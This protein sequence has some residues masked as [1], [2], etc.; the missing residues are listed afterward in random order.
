MNHCELRLLTDRDDI[1]VNDI[2]QTTNDNNKIAT[3]RWITEIILRNK[4][5]EIH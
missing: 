1:T 4:E 2:D 5:K 3:I